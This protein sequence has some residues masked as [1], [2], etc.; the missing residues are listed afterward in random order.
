MNKI[1]RLSI[2]FI[3]AC[4]C[5]GIVMYSARKASQATAASSGIEGAILVT[6]LEDELNN[7]GD[8]SLRE[9]ITAANDNT[10]VD[11]CRKGGVGTDTITFDVAGIITVTSE[12]SVTA[13]GPLVI[14]GGGVISTSGGGTTR[15]WWVDIDAQLSLLNMIIENGYIYGM[16]GAGIVNFDGFLIISKSLIINNKAY[17]LYYEGAQIGGTGGGIWNSGTLIL[18]DSTVSGN[19]SGNSIGA[20]INAGII[21]MTNSTLSGN[22]GGEVGNCGLSNPPKTGNI[23]ISNSTIYSPESIGIQVYTGTVIITNTVIAGTPLSEGCLITNG[24]V[25]DGGHNISSDDSCGF[26][27]ANGSMPNTDPL[28]TP[29]QDNGGP[30]WMHALLWNSP[31]IDAGDDTQCPDNDQR[32]VIR[33]LDGNG[34]GT[35]VCDIGA[36]EKVYQP[37]IL[38]PMVLK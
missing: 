23:F 5:L 17:V 8:C 19:H 38:L 4:L 27:T 32:G 3:M 9:A 20:I 36:Y 37:V 33:P 11:Q 18:L 24:V 28:L 21:T 22:W 25:T 13:G 16:D 2:P 7:D 6:T 15:V 10:H 30:T 31:A 29:L 14:D 26:D 12:L 34:D 1:L 35:A